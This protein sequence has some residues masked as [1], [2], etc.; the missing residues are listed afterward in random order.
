MEKGDIIRI[1][2]GE[3]SSL[4]EFKEKLAGK[5]L[6]VLEKAI[7]AST[8]EEKA[9]CYAGSDLVVI[10]RDDGSFEVMTCLEEELKRSAARLAAD[11]R[12]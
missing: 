5:E 6:L 1:R 4:G 12:A 10:L 9:V 7:D 8:G 3:C 11:N 2:D